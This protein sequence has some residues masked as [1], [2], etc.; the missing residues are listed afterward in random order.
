[1][2]IYLKEAKHKNQA[3]YLSINKTWA[4]QSRKI[5]M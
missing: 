4:S 2:H 5:W 1:M 3:K